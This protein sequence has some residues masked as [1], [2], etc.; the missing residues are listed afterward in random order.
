M[1]YWF[2]GNCSAHVL[3]HRKCLQW[4]AMCG[5]CILLC[6]TLSIHAYA[7]S[8]LDLQVLQAVNYVQEDECILSG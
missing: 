8:I 4:D 2:N 3:T 1:K 6:G 7:V 5:I